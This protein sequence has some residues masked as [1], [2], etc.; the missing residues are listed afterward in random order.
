MTAYWLMKSEP[1]AFSWD[2][3]VSRGAKGES[4]DGVRNYQARNNMR[5][6][7]VGDLGF[8]YHSNEG[9]EIVGVLRVIA[10][11]HPEAKDETGKWECVDV[12]SV[13]AMPKPVKLDDVKLNPK[14]ADMVLVNNARLSVQPVKPEEW[15]EICR[16]GGLDLKKLKDR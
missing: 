3:L 8:F 1:D 2:D 16:A 11:A 13:T 6:M 12:A 9:K 5:A 15:K 10:K 14:L 7:Q 4:W